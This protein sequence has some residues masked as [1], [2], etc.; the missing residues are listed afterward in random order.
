MGPHLAAGYGRSMSVGA[1]IAVVGGGV[2]GLTTGVA[3]LEAGLSVRLMAA[4]VPGPTSLAAGAMWGPYLV[5]PWA[6]VR[7]WSLTSLSEFRSL[8]G[9][10]T[11]GVRRWRPLKWCSRSWLMCAPGSPP[12]CPWW[13]ARAP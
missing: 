12:R 13:T 11:T 5:E 6:R 4:E 2:S 7:E 3:L 10:P 9:D 1:R 8:A